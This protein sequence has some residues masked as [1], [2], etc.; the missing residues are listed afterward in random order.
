MVK[1]V[2]YFET[3]MRLAHELGQARLSRDPVRIARA[4]RR[5]DEYA[6]LCLDSDE[7][8]IGELT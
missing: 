2:T 6:Q 8:V 4:Q 5:H 3:L 7:M 1:V